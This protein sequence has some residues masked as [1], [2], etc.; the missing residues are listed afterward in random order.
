MMR[1]K[2]IPPT[3]R[4]PLAAAAFLALAA[5]SAQP[6]QPPVHPAMPASW[7]HAV[8]WSRVAAPTPA[9]DWWRVFGDAR[10]NALEPRVAANNAQLA[11]QLAVYEQAQAALRQAG[12][13]LWPTASATL[14]ATRQKV[15]TGSTLAGSVGNDFNAGLA[16]SWAPDLWGRVRLQVRA[17]GDAA[18]ADAATLRGMRL[19]LQAQ[20]AQA[21]LQLHVADAQIALA[22]RV[23][24]A[25]AQTLQLT[26]RRLAA[27]VAT[28]A[29]VAAARTQ[30]LQAGAALTDL[31]VGRAQLVDAIAVLVGQ[32]PSSLSL[33]A[34]PALPAVPRIP[35]GLPS[36][37]LQRRPDLIAA[38]AQ[39]D[40]AN[41]QLGI[42]ERAW[43]PDLTLGAQGGAQAL[44]AAGLFGAPALTWSL[45]PQLA[46]TLFDGGARAA[47]RAASGAAYRGSVA[48]YRQAVL[49]ALQQVEDQLAAQRLLEIEQRQQAAVVRAA[50]VSLKLAQDQYRAGTAPY[51]NVLS[52]DNVAA[53]AAN[54]LLTLQ[55]RRYVAAVALVQALGGSWGDE[56]ALAR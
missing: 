21:V 38:A 7:G 2:P 20:L 45:G 40:A 28:A 22:R 6:P 39:V 50:N 47:Q 41:A 54:A 9:R 4:R 35:P 1:T 25:D 53:Q 29:D 52:A 42:A 8:A 18:R 13:A 49:V 32:P 15:G 44:T 34:A 56:A 46:A 23:A 55:Q 30:Q 3:W 37:L 27:G 33:P 16:V 26:Q 31:Q 10:L 48:S 19:S 12:A 24:A 11:A 5:C 17:S 51:L 36:A 43:F 14:G